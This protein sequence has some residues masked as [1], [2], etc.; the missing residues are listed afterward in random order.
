MSELESSLIFRDLLAPSQVRS[1]EKTF[2]TPFIERS[3]Q[4]FD[5]DNVERKQNVH[6]F[7]PT[8]ALDGRYQMED[9]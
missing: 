7:A 2:S 1:A 9:V 4:E 5:A 6:P 3:S 8:P